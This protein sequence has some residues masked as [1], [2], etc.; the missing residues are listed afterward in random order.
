MCLLFMDRSFYDW[1]VSY[2][3]LFN[4]SKSSYVLNKKLSRVFQVF[5]RYLLSMDSANSLLILYTIKGVVL[6][7]LFSIIKNKNKITLLGGL[8]PPAFRLTAERASRLRHKSYNRR[9][10]SEKTKLFV[11]LHLVMSSI[12]SYPHSQQWTIYHDSIIIIEPIYSINIISYDED[13]LKETN[14]FN[15]QKH[16]IMYLN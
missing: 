11:H 12:C 3:K 13:S 9:F 14:K 5:Y 4:F 10:F 2:F 6:Q 7:R 15:D 8:E 1:F 16:I